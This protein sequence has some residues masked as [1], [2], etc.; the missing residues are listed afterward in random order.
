MHSSSCSSP[1]PSTARPARQ[2]VLTLVRKGGSW[3]W[4]AAGAG[5]RGSRAR[6]A[7]AAVSTAV[8]RRARVIAGLRVTRGR[9]VACQDGA[10]RRATRC[11]RSG[12]ALPRANF[13][14]LSLPNALSPNNVVTAVAC[15]SEHTQDT[16][17]TQCLSWCKPTKQHCEHTQAPF[18]SS[19]ALL[20]SPTATIQSGR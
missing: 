3:S 18:P 11:E 8:H 13:S 7:Q 20:W 12:M 4:A 2:S 15:A 6:A 16:R 9:R 19:S 17:T 1:C 14:R 5:K 10:D